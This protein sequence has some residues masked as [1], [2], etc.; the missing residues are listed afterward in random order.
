MGLFFVDCT[1]EGNKS[2][3]VTVSFA[4]VFLGFHLTC[5]IV[6]V[7]AA[8]PFTV[9]KPLIGTGF[10]FFIAG[11]ALGMTIFP[12]IDGAILSGTITVFNQDKSDEY[13]KGNY[14]FFIMF[15]FLLGAIM[16]LMNFW[17]WFL[18][19]KNGN[20]LS[21]LIKLSDKEVKLIRR[22]TSIAG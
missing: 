10:G 17:L 1:V 12:L 2:C 8:V 4:Q 5:C 13:S 14:D 9:D 11:R 19:K 21:T 16:T 20:K 3:Y 15:F 7:T 6:A 22:H 18:D